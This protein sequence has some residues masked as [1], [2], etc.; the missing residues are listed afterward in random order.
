MHDFSSRI[1][2]PELLDGGQLHDEE[3]RRTLLDLRWINRYFGTRKVLLR[4]L[5]SEISRRGL[6]EFTVLDVASGS[7]DLPIAVIHWAQRRKLKT[8]VFALEYQHRHLGLFRRELM[9]Y[10]ELYPFC[11]DAFRVPLLNP[12]F[13]FVIC[14]HFL[15]HLTEEQAVELLSRMSTWARHV[16][17]VSDHE[18]HPVPY[19]FFRL[20]SRLFTT[21]FVSRTDGLIS[22]AKSFRKD[23]LEKTAERAGLARYRVERH[24]P[25]QLILISDSGR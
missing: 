3:V 9:T 24:W 4:A 20:F 15:H 5:A 21:S 25:F 18:R 14:S 11:A 10:R 1:L 7:C 16:V 17:I 12:K 22:L 2:R 8:Q 23:E 6:T 13:D 19:Y